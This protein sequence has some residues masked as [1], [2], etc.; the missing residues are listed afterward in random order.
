[1]NKIETIEC[2]REGGLRTNGHFKKSLPDKPLISIITIVFNGEKYLEDTILNIIKQSYD[3][4]EYV[5]IDGV[6]TD[7]TLEIIKKYEGEIDYWVSEPDKGLYDA[8]N[9]G[10]GLANGDWVNFMNAGD[11]FYNTGMIDSLVNYFKEDASLIYG[12]VRVA[13]TDHENTQKADKFSNL[14]KGMICCHQ[15][16]FTRR[17]ALIELMFNLEYNLASDYEFLCRFYIQGYKAKKIDM[18]ISRI[19]AGGQADS[20]RIETL[21]ELQKISSNFFK[22]RNVFTSIKFKI[23]ILIQ[24]LKRVLIKAEKIIKRK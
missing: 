23:L 19:I 22:S 18:V 15:S 7:R 11:V 4:V 8:M 5:V 14:W 2:K 1:M 21:L 17:Q 3:N 9:K 20:R 6:S 16:I 13:Y 12:D 10:I 24:L